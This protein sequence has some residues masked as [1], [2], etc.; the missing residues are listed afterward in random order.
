MA[1]S[2]LENKDEDNID[3]NATSGD[4]R[5]DGARHRLWVAEPS[6]RLRQKHAGD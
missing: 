5:H 4:A 2:I 1:T 3:D 6:A